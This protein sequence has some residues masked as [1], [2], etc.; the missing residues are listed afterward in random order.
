MNICH[1]DSLVQSFCPDLLIRD[2][3]PGADRTLIQTMALGCSE[4]TV[5]DPNLKVFL[6]P[7]QNKS[8]DSDTDT[9]FQYGSR[10]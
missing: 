1:L 4:L 5:A 2:P 9:I 6:H 8:S 3:H 7:N 10:A